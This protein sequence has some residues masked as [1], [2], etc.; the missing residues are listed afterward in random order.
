MMAQASPVAR[1]PAPAA[2]KDPKKPSWLDKTHQRFV[3]ALTA[4][5]RVEEE[6]G[7]FQAREG[8]DSAA[9][10]VLATLARHL[11]TLQSTQTLVVDEVEKLAKMRWEPKGAKIEKALFAVGQVVEIAEDK[12]KHFLRHGL[13]DAAVIA[14]PAK[15][16]KI[17][18]GQAA[19][20]LKDGSIISPIAAT[21]LVGQP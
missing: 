5:K 21:W 19:I 14:A 8:V 4:A 3:S 9:R 7:I 12:R 16:E 2:E 6:V 1:R 17:V 15:V 20:K 10:P 11:K 18:G 13:Y